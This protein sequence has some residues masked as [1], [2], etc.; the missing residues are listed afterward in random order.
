MELVIK[1]TQH[2]P[3]IHFQWDQDGA[4]LR[5]SEL[6]PKLDK[7]LKEKNIPELKELFGAKE[8]LPYKLSVMSKDRRVLCKKE[9]ENGKVDFPTFFGNIK[10]PK[11][12]E[13]VICD[14]IELRFISFH[15]NLLEVISNNIAE[16]MFYTNFGTRQSKGFGSFY[17]RN[18]DQENLYKDPCLFKRPYF[19]VDESNYEDELQKY[20]ALFNYIDLFYKTL[21]SGINYQG[22]YFK[23]LL[24]SYVKNKCWTW[25]KKVYKSTFLDKEV[26]DEQIEKHGSSDVLTYVTDKKYLVRDLLGL[27]AVQ[28]YSS[29]TKNLNSKLYNYSI[30]YDE[31]NDIKRFKSPLLFKPI[32]NEEGNRFKVFLIVNEIPDDIF[33]KPFSVNYYETEKE[34]KDGKV[35]KNK[36]KVGNLTIFTPDNFDLKDYLNFAL[37]NFQKNTINKDHRFYIMISNIYADLE[38]SIKNGCEF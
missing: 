7:Y 17:V 38:R 8:N 3:I 4:T 24:F 31:K 9:G 30:E 25:D 37:R 34:T 19:C 32:L 27:A 20:E 14:D 15:Q 28:Q 12:K 11:R 36:K 1:L 18:N 21:R 2:T 16:F 23:S 29:Y 35:T 22:F 10:V 33:R 26:L 6:K 5:A 13:Y